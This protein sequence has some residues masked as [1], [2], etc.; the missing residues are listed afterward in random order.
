MAGHPM[1]GG[2]FLENRNFFGT[3]RLGI[4]AAGPE[5]AARGQVD[6]RGDV[7]FEDDLLAFQLRVR[8]GDGGE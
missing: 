5:D 6:G 3:K 1:A 4:G 2:D 7:A 8:D